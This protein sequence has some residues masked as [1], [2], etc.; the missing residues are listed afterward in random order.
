MGHA[1]H[2]APGAVSRKLMVSTSA[3]ALFVAFEFVVGFHANSLALIGDAFHNLTDTFALLLAL[4]VV[5][6]ERR[7]ATIEKSFGYQ[8][9]GVVAAFVNA[10][11]LLAFTILI[12]WE[13]VQRI[14]RPEPVAS[15]WM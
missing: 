5:F 8:R 14:R 15:D 10:G 6:I 11:T 9:A 1:H 4:V 2:H 12:F 3:T 13:A 7:P